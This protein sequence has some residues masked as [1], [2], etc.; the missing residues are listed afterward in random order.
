MEAALV[1]WS[2]HLPAPSCS[3]FCPQM[4]A[5]ADFVV[6][7]LFY[8]VDRYL[9]FVKDC[10]WVHGVDC[11][12]GRGWMLGCAAEL[13]ARDRYLQLIKDCLWVQHSTRGWVWDGEAA[14][15]APPIVS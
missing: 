2:P 15:A 12:G 3:H 4:E 8:D 14:A 7:Q 9:Q 11:G 10:R 6:T 13:G 5:G 1:L